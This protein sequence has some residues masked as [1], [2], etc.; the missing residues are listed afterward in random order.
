[1]FPWHR[2][3]LK[4]GPP[5][6]GIRTGDSAPVPREASRKLAVYEQLQ[7]INV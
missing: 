7:D 3:L 5:L 1:M 2:K 4:E 6:S